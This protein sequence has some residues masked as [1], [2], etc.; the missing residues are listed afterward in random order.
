L[1]LV[2]KLLNKSPTQALFMSP[3]CAKV[4]QLALAGSLQSALVSQTAATM[5]LLQ[6]KGML[7]LQLAL[8]LETAEPTAQ[9]GK[10]PAPVITV[11][12]QTSLGQS[13]GFW[14]PTI[15]FPSTLASNPP[16]VVEPP[17][18]PPEEVVVEFVPPE[19]LVV[20]PEE[21]PPV[22][23]PPLV[24]LEVPPSASGTCEEVPPQASARTVTE[25][26]VRTK[27]RMS[28]T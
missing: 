21:V 20:A 11:P 12:Q 4:Q 17:E 25:L 7:V 19:E 24:L 9:L 16:E 1:Q 23:V 22:L 3:P 6:L 13:A 14:Q 28:V 27:K 2:A 5:V 8:Q 15:T 26:K 10:V 18:P